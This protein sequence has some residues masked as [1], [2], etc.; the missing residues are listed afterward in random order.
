MVRR[1][2]L[3]PTGGPD[4]EVDERAARGRYIPGLLTLRGQLDIT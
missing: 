4:E 1:D 2:L 3:G